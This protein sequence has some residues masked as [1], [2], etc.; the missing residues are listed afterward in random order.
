[1]G[2]AASIA[3]PEAI[4]FADLLKLAPILTPGSADTSVDIDA[5]RALFKKRKNSSFLTVDS[6]VSTHAVTYKLQ[7]GTRMDI[8]RKISLWSWSLRS[9]RIPR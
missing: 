5:L 7:I 1:M 3:V 2:S 9:Q 8:F 6:S 4:H